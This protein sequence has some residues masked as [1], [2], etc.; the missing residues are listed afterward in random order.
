MP[1]STFP[2]TEIDTFPVIDGLTDDMSAV[3]HDDLHNHVSDAI[4]ATQAKLGINGS[5]NVHSIDYLLT[6]PLSVDP[7]HF[8]TAASI[9]DFAAAVALV[10]P[11]TN[12]GGSNT[13]V[14]YNSGG[15]FAG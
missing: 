4:I 1:S 8:H 12:P 11:P 6:N 5:A 3:P 9:T 15:S 7:G 13:H 10:S 2:E 14:Q